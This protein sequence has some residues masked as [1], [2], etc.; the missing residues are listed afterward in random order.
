M[1]LSFSTYCFPNNLPNYF[2]V[3]FSQIANALFEKFAFELIDIQIN[4]FIYSAFWN[5]NSTEIFFY[6]FQITTNLFDTKYSFQIKNLI[7]NYVK[8]KWNNF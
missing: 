6:N 2:K 4:K 7:N 3:S 5:Q 1:L 8:C